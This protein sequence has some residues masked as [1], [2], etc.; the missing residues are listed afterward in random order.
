MG[1]HTHRHELSLK[2]KPCKVLDTEKFCYRE[3]AIRPQAAGIFA[4]PSAAAADR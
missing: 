4:H 2:N 1:K 3:S